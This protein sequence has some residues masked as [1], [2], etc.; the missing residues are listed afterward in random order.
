MQAIQYVLHWLPWP[1]TI[2]FFVLF[3][4]RFGSKGLAVFTFFALFYMVLVD[5]WDES[6]NTL[7]LVAISVPL[8]IAVGLFF[9]VLAFRSARF[10][11]IVQPT[12]DLMQTVPAFAYLIPILFLFGFG[13]VV[14][15]I[16]SII[17]ASPPMVRNTILGL[18]EVPADIIESGIMSGCKP[19]QL[20]WQVELPTAT[21]QLLIGV[22]Q[23]T[24]AAL[25]MVIIAAIIGGFD[26]IGWEVLSTMRKARFGESLLA[27]L[28]IA[29]LA[30]VL[31]RLSA[32]VATR[33]ASSHH[34][35]ENPLKRYK[36][37]LASLGALVVFKVLGLFFPPIASFP[38]SW[39]F[40][41]ADTL[42]TGMRAFVST[43]GDVLEK[44]KT[45]ALFYLMFP[46]R[47]GFDTSI[48]P[49]TWGFALTPVMIWAYALA[50]AGISA[51]TY[52]RGQWRGAVAIATIAYLLYF[53][54]TGT[55]W[56]IFISIITLLAYQ[57]G[58]SRTALFAFCSM[59]FMLIN[60]L[61][62]PAM[63]SIYLCSVAVFISFSI[64]GLIGIWAAHN[65]T[66]SRIVRPINDTLQTMPPFVLLIPALM[67]FKVGEF[68]AMLAII[69]YA[70]VPAIRYVEHGLRSVPE[71]I[72]EAA[73]QVGCTPSQMLLQVKLPIA[74]PVIMLGLNQTIMYGLA[75]L[76]IAALVGTQDLGQQ[77]YLALTKADMGR[78]IVTGVSM[79][80]IAMVADRI[81]QAF[82]RKWQSSM[83]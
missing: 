63:L 31:D 34:L 66:V 67:L 53:G 78:G 79:A 29:L 27:G 7:A 60:G 22:N 1:A 38:E 42:N 77:I 9:G 8:S 13:P 18:R 45:S 19:R 59:V 57:G 81:I 16:A 14:G 40:Y 6:M 32:A 5:Y 50:A 36:F 75:M 37:L 11:A 10:N 82:S 74:L 73:T 2:A 17:F 43:F 30:M 39:T 20:F 65:D 55:P 41:P 48:N 47:N 12:L 76:V 62:E 61:W 3:A 49:F 54:L 71:N 80:L 24:M 52:T 15:V 68:T 35:E 72:V 64:G 23:S 21:P 26:D 4:L 70:I 56:A 28:V 33:S 46:I 83:S 51:W 25:S 58:G 44:V 69:S